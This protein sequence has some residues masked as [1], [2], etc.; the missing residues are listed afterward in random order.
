MSTAEPE[1]SNVADR[2]RPVRGGALHTALAFGEVRVGRGEIAVGAE[3]LPDLI[4]TQRGLYEQAVA[5]AGV[6][7]ENVLV[8]RVTEAG[9][10][11]DAVDTDDA[12]WPVRT[13]R[14]AADDL[15]QL[16]GRV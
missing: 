9:I 3:S 12:C 6:E 15:R 2:G 4:P 11:V 5:A 8:V 1:R 14:V 10:E 7:P 16:V 13:R